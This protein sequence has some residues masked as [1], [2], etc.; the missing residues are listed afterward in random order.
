[1]LRHSQRMGR[2]LQII[3]RTDLPDHVEL[4]D[5]RP[6][7]FAANH[8]SFLDIAVAMAMF[9]HLSITSR[10]QVRADIFDKHIIGPWVTGLRCIPTNKDVR[11]EAEATALATLEAG[12]T[13]AIMPEGRLVPPKD[14]PNGVG[15]ARTG[16]SRIVRQS[17]A[18]VVPVAIYGSDAIWPKKRP[19]PKLGLFRRRDLVVRL[20]PP[21]D[22]ADKDHQ[23]NADQLMAT[24]AAMLREIEGDLARA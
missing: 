19:I 23:V 6:V 5:D 8:R 22:F 17:G 21:I 1:M 24:I 20:G 16:I 4:P 12:S 10:M 18:M 14:R 15:A 13:V 11:A 9:G 3:A 7:V 2:I